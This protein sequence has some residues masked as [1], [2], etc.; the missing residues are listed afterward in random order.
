MGW[1]MDKYT[2]VLD[3]GGVRESRVVRAKNLGSAMVAGI[4]WLHSSADLGQAVEVC[5]YGTGEL[6]ARKVVGSLWDYYEQGGMA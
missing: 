5:D 4:R 3:A 2:L 6:L 1:L